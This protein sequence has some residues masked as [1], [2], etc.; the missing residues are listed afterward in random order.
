MGDG[1]E[2]L[3]LM[4]AALE[5]I[6]DAINGREVV[7]QSAILDH[8]DWTDNLDAS[9]YIDSGITVPAGAAVQCFKAEWTEA[10]TVAGAAGETNINLQVGTAADPDRLCQATDPD[11]VLATGLPESFVQDPRNPGDVGD[12]DI[13]FTS[14]TQLRILGTLTGGTP[15]FSNFINAGGSGKLKLTVIYKKTADL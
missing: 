12:G 10:P 6:R 8:E 5:E 2:N 3:P 7:A 13:V 4:V 1:L 14:A 11:T 9:G 15:D